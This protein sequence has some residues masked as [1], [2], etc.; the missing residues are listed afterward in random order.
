MSQNKNESEVDDPSVDSKE[1]DNKDGNC[2]IFSGIGEKIEGAINTIQGMRS[3]LDFFGNSTGSGAEINNSY[4]ADLLDGWLEDSPD[5]DILLMIYDQFITE[6]SY[7]KNLSTFGYVD[8][9]IPSSISL[10]SDDFESKD[11]ISACI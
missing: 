6:S 1:E 8:Y 4:F 10:Y 9:A 3:A 2:S 7:E 11:G 5:E